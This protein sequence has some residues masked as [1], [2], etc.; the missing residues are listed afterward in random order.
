MTT[1]AG[2]KALMVDVDGV[3]ITPRLGG[4]AADLEA[5]LGVSKADLAEQFF[6][7]HWPEVVLGNAGLH[8]RLGPVLARIAPGVS[9]YELAAYWFAK[10][11][12]LDYQL[13]DD[14][15]LERARGVQAHLATVQEHE[16]A[17]YIWDRLGLRGQ[18]DALHYSA[19][20][21]AKKS[22]P[23]FYAAVEARTGFSGRE[24]LLI[25]DTAENAAAARAAGWRGAHWTGAQRLSEVLADLAGAA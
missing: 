22:D 10:D 1:L 7:V 19:D 23:E 3:V 18:F 8:E 6:A 16:R 11:S 2:L 17:A 15:A 4:W 20:L 12:V 9:S 14:L 5:D 24:L 21:G 13:L 25:D